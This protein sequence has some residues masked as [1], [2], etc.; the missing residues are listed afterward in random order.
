MEWG[1]AGRGGGRGAGGR[2]GGRA[3]R[4]V[5]WRGVASGGGAGRSSGLISTLFVFK[6]SQA[7][8]NVQPPI[9]RIYNRNERRRQQANE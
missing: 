1:G 2:A 5:A 4:G 6:G 7:S 3:G 8:A 9:G